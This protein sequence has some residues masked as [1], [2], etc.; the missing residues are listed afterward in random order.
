MKNS[1]VAVQAFTHIVPGAKNKHPGAQKI[2]LQI[3]T[4]LSVGGGACSRTS[5]GQHT[6]C[7]HVVGARIELRAQGTLAAEAF[8][9]R[10]IRTSRAG[11]CQRKIE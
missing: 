11:G 9:S 7:A 5:T 8:E 2:K 10:R 1:Y 6:A 3:S 4:F